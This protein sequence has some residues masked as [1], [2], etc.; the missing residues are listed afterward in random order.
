M[1][2]QLDQRTAQA[3]YLAHSQLSESLS[4]YLGT[5]YCWY[6]RCNTKYFVPDREHYSWFDHQHL[7]HEI[8]IGNNGDK[9]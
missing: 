1:S 8:G 3:R 6:D 9:L 7:A 4:V 5:C 2:D